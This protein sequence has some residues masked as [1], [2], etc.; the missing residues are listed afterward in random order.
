MDRNYHIITASD[1]EVLRC[2]MF[3]LKQREREERLFWWVNHIYMP[4]CVIGTIGM[5]LFY[6]W[7]ATHTRMFN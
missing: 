2:R 6:V 5:I 7:V 1:L 3:W 4:I